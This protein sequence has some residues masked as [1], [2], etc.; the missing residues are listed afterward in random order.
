MTDCVCQLHGLGEWLYNWQT[1]LSGLLALGAAIWA[2]YLLRAQISQSEKLH[3]K[4]MARRHIAAKLTM[5]LALS[6]MAALVQ[7]VADEISS[8]LE[9]YGDGLDREFDAILDGRANRRKFEPI[10]ISESIISSFSRFAETLSSPEEIKHVSEL[11]ATAQILFSRY[12]GQDLQGAGARYNLESLLL[13]AATLR[14]LIDSMFN[15]ARSLDDDS[16]ALVGVKADEE[17]W[18]MIQRAAHGLI[19]LRDRRDRF[20]PLI[21][22]RIQRYREG[23]S[24]P[25]L[26]KFQP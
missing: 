11:I 13:D 14:V 7:S 12:N 3:Q 10:E 2:G 16:F 9:T 1:L 21:D 6:G 20:I 22:R 26:E 8:E 23:G 18:E 17:V 4:E 24:S 5:P 15:Y 25:W 19:F